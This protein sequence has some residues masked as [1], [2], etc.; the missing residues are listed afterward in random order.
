MD[1]VISDTK[2]ACGEQAAAH[3]ARLVREAIDARG[4]ATIIVATG[5]SQFDMLAALV[6]TPG[7]DWTRVAGFHLDE[8]I[9]MPITHPA[10]FR[11]YLKERF[12]DRLPAPLARFHYLSGEGD[13]QIECRR[14]GQVLS[15]RTVDAAFIGIGENGHLAFNDPPAD[16]RTEE[17]YIVV[18]LDAACRRQQLGEGWFETL[19]DVPRRAISMS[20]RQIL[21]A[22]AIV[23]TVPDARKAEAV[24]AAIEGPVTP[25]CPSSI[26][27]QHPA[28]TL[29]LDRDS[30]SLLKR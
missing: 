17:P 9:G 2:E 30:A 5:A 26:L 13:P 19:D 8:Y 20:I 11:K 18:D 10:S 7:I 15:R 27:Q 3:G 29:F 16:F 12:V 4:R 23:C 6:G 22:A 14:V 28:T 21:K 1:I 25:Q 24:R